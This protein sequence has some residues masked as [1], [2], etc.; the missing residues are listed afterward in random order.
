MIVWIFKLVKFEL[1]VRVYY[2]MNDIFFF[3]FVGK[4]FII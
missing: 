1:K 2:S 3:L 4:I